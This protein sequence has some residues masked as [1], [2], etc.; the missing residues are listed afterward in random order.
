MT[1]T[2][3]CNDIHVPVTA[4][5]LEALRYLRRPDEPRLLWTDLCCIHQAD[6]VEKA[7]QV[8]MMFA[9]FQRAAGVVA[10][11]GTP[12]PEDELVC[13]IIDVQAGETYVNLETGMNMLEMPVKVDMYMEPG[14]TDPNRDAARSAARAF[15]TTR[16]FFQ[17]TWIRQE[18]FAARRLDLVC[19]TYVFPFKRFTETI[20]QLLPEQTTDGG[21]FVGR[22]SSSDDPEAGRALQCYSYFS[23]DHD[24]DYAISS[25]NLP[26]VWFHNAMRSA[27]YRSSLAHDKVYAVLGMSSWQTSTVDSPSVPDPETD[28]TRGFPRPD[29]TRPAGLV[30]QDFAKHH[31][32]AAR[33]LRCLS[34][35][36][37]LSLRG[38]DLP[39]WAV[40]LRVDAPRYLNTQQLSYWGIEW[41]DE[42]PEQDFADH[43][44]LAVR[45][46][47]V[48]RVGGS[49]R[50]EQGG[51]TDPWE[52][53]Y[54]RFAVSEP[55]PMLQSCNDADE[56]W[57]PRETEKNDEGDDVERGADARLEET[58]GLLRRDCGYTWVP[59]GERLAPLVVQE[60]M[61][62]WPGPPGEFRHH[63]FV[64]SLVRE[65]DLIVHLG[66]SD[67]ACVLRLVEGEEEEEQEEED[68][69]EE[70]I[71]DEDDEEK[72]RQ[73]REKDKK[74]WKFLGPALLTMGMFDKEK[75][76]DGKPVFQHHMARVDDTEID[77]EAKARDFMLV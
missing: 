11:V 54:P 44:R 34:I 9:I 57:L 21:R 12:S 13:R 77:R 1:E 30:F 37:D 74:R 40:D 61:Y 75:L 7:H 35:F 25:I 36:Q 28:V 8:E 29:Y 64:S 67:V 50:T 38:D 46:I 10:W 58:L 45:G 55:N 66:G 3:L 24:K 23:R 33:T 19:G 32:N 52:A 42:V 17:R 6:L 22:S 68:F 4:T 59:V 51:Q 41:E 48:A 49:S 2:I 27:M 71:D 39:S 60:D 14:E 43:G 31:V 72:T 70:E 62:D 69:D 65:G 53:S 20:G 15:I 76:K 5:L 18:I 47:R 16:P 63:A 56:H 73:R 26:S